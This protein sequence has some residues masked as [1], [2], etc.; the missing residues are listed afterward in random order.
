MGRAPVL[1][2]AAKDGIFTPLVRVVRRVVGK[3]RF[4]KAKSKII[5]EHTKVIQA[6][7]ETSDSPFGCIALQTLFEL[8]DENSDGT[9]DRDELEKAL[10]KLGFY[11][12]KDAQLD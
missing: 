9:I 7:V 4:N 8:A 3:D 1:K 10:K 11:H 5:A 12:L 6:F 2:G